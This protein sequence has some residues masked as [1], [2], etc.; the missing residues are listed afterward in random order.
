MQK[1]LY[2]ITKIYLLNCKQFEFH[3]DETKW[4]KIQKQ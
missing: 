2:K 1:L 3:I 4:K